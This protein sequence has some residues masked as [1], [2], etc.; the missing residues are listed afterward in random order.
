MISFLLSSR[1]QYATHDRSVQFVFALYHV[2]RIILYAD[3]EHRQIAFLFEGLVRHC[4][5]QY[6]IEIPLRGRRFRNDAA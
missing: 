1:S 2:S 4:Y 5:W 6:A 3:D